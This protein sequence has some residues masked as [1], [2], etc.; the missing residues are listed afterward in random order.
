MAAATSVRL[1]A[2]LPGGGLQTLA[3]GAVNA[4]GSFSLQAPLNVGLAIAQALNGAG[5]VVGSVIVGATEW[6]PEAPWSPRR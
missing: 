5:Q 2:L 1:S 6:S 3:Q 4:A